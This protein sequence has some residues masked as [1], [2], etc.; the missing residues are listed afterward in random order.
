MKGHE[1]Y[2]SLFEVK[3]SLSLS[4]S[5]SDLLLLYTYG[6]SLRLMMVLDT[7][8]LINKLFEE[9]EITRP[10]YDKISHKTEFLSYLL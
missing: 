1:L 6:L 10:E 8:D 7:F 4:L 2:K 9:G 5:L 3:I